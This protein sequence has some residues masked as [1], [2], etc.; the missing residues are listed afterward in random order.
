M[1]YNLTISEK[2]VTGYVDA[3]STVIAFLNNKNNDGWT[4]TQI[5]ANSAVYL[6]MNLTYASS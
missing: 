5:N 6:N 4:T 3:G 2:Y 1:L